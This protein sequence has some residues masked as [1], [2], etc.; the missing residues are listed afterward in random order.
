[1]NVVYHWLAINADIFFIDGNN[2]L[3]LV[4]GDNFN[5]YLG[6]GGNDNWYLDI[7]EIYYWYQALNYNNKWYLDIQLYI[8]TKCKI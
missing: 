7:D 1:M 6:M 2:L 5:I 8:V 4:S 3:Y